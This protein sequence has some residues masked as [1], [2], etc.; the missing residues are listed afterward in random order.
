MVLLLLRHCQRGVIVMNKF[1]IDD[2]FNIPEY[3]QVVADMEEIYWKTGRKQFDPKTDNYNQIG[4]KGEL[5]W[6]RKW[7]YPWALVNSDILIKDALTGKLKK[8]EELRKLRVLDVGCGCAPF[9]P[10]LA[11]LGCESYGI[12]PDADAVNT[13]DGLAG[14][15]PDLGKILKLKMEIKQAGMEDIPYPDNYFDRVYCISVIEHVSDEVMIA[16][17]REMSRVL[18]YGGLLTITMDTHNPEVELP[19]ARKIIEASGLQVY[20][21]TNFDFNNPYNCIKGIDNYRQGRYWVFGF[22]LEKR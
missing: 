9:L 21:E 7:E 11:T 10:Y 3:Q 15:D 22:I 1:A 17:A 16:G 5:Y 6:S 19:R 8:N 20:G 14:F 4:R 18:A 2:D 12:T 13:H